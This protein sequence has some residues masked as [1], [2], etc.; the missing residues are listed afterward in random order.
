MNKM[1]KAL[2]IVSILSSSAIYCVTQDD[3][4]AKARI[5][6]DLYNEIKDNETYKKMRQLRKEFKSKV[7]YGFLLC[8]QSLDKEVKRVSGDVSPFVMKKIVCWGFDISFFSTPLPLLKSVQEQ[9]ILYNGM[10]FVEGLLWD[11]ADIGNIY[12]SIRNEWIKTEEYK[13]LSGNKRAFKKTF[14]SYHLKQAWEFDSLYENIKTNVSEKSAKK[15]LE[16]RKNII[17]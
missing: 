3:V 2:S 12:A 7:L 10:D 11:V 13:K 5:Y 16:W 14:R 4:V 1:I 9:T 17:T 8:G 6:Q 15:L